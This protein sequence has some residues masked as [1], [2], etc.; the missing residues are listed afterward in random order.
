MLQSNI[1]FR[2]YT[3]LSQKTLMQ[4]VCHPHLSLVVLVLAMHLPLKLSGMFNTSMSS[5]G[6]IGFYY[7]LFAYQIFVFSCPSSRVWRT[8]TGNFSFFWWYRNRYRKNLVP[9]KSLGTGIGKIW[10]RKKSLGTGI[11]KIWYRKKVSVKYQKNLVSKK[12]P[13]IGIG[14]GTV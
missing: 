13:G 3:F 6:I 4:Y 14:I 10:Y 2:N 12:S 8:G 5:N 11:G 9:E 1:N 7:N